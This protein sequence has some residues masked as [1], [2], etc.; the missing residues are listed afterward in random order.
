MKIVK[1]ITRIL[2]TSSSWTVVTIWW[3]RN[4]KRPG[5][6]SRS[7]TSPRSGIRRTTWFQSR[8]SWSP[9]NC[10]CRRSGT[11]DTIQ[12]HVHKST[13]GWR[14]RWRNRWIGLVR[15]IYQYNIRII[16]L[17][18]YKQSKIVKKWS[19]IWFKKYNRHWV[20][21]N[22]ETYVILLKLWI[23]FSMKSI[24]LLVFTYCHS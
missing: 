8:S 5:W 6:F 1:W 16:I 14:L 19:L 18:T 11:A 22:S 12:W 15:R 21:Y 3:Q 23:L 9:S 4:W 24:K 10:N 2:C 17:S 7:V 13:R 20:Y